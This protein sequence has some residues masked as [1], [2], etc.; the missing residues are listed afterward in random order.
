MGQESGC[1]ASVAFI[2]I[3]LHRLLQGQTSPIPA[4][5]KHPHAAYAAVG[6]VLGNLTKMR[7]SKGRL[8]GWRAS[9]VE[10][11]VMKTSSNRG[12]MLFLD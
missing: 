10:G 5:C 6:G 9:S 1:T 3:F 8:L 11:N 2:A 4:S 7:K 12:H